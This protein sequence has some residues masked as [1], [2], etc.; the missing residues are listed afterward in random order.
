MS[1]AD[2]TDANGR[3][4]HRY[5]EA[6][7][8]LSVWFIKSDNKTVDY[9]VHELEILPHED[10]PTGRSGWRAKAHHLCINDKYDVKYEFRF[11]GA[12]IEMWTLGYSV[13]GPNKDYRIESVYRR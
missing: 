3:Y 11:K 1:V 7:D 5:Q 10:R 12:N 8:T 6:T 2:V 4:A 9:L 13:K